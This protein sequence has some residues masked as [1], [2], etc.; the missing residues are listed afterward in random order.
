MATKTFS[1]IT[2]WGEAS[3]ELIIEV[4]TEDGEISAASATITGII[5]GE[6]AFAG[7]AELAPVLE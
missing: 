5:E 7:E 1:G 6:I 2:N 4:T 3:A